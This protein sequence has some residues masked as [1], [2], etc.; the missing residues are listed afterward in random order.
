MELDKDVVNL[1]KAIR[2]VESGGK[3]DARS[4][5]GS[6][7]AY[8]FIKPT[9]DATAKK[10]GVNA[11][12][13][14][15]TP[16]QQNEVAYKQIKEW[17]DKGYNVGQISSM[18]NAGAGRPNAYKEGLSGVNK[19]GV[20]YNVAKYAEKV[21]TNYQKIKGAGMEVPPA[22]EVKTGAEKVGGV[23]DTILGGA[24]IGEAI[25]AS[26]VRNDIRDGGAI[27]GNEVIEA[28][29]SK[30]S[31]E[32]IERLRQKGVPIS[33]QAQIEE[34]AQTV[35]GPSKTQLFG[36]VAR[37]GLNFLP[38]G[39]IIKGG[40]KAVPLLNKL[41]ATAGNLIEGAGIAGLAN[42]AS[43]VAN[44]KPL[45]ENLGTSLALGGA[46]GAGL[47]V[48]IKGGS[49]VIKYATQGA[50]KKAENAVLSQFKKGVKPLINTKMTAGGAEKYD[51]N[52]IAG[53][54]TIQNNKA[55]LSFTDEAGEVFTGET[56]RT[57]QQF[58]D[59]IEQTKKVIFNSYDELAKTA[60][61][62]GVQVDMKPI[63][64]ELDTIINNKALN[65]TN[66]QAIKYAKNLKT[67][68]A[69]TGKLDATT[70]QEV[71][72]NYNKSLEAFYRNPSYETATQASID[73]MIANNMRKA[74]DEGITGL[75]GT[76]YGALKKQYGALKAIEKDVIKASLRDA[77]KNTKGLIDFT[78]VFSGGQ[79]VNGI[80]S[81]NPAQIGSGLAQ[82][83]IASFYKYL[84]NPNRAI[85]KLFTSA[86]KL[87]QLNL[88]KN[89]QT[90]KAINPNTNPSKNVI[91]KPISQPK[92]KVKPSLSLG[93]VEK[94]LEPLAQEARK[95]KSA[96]AFYKAQPKLFR[97]GS[98]LDLSRGSNR[99]I[100]FTKTAQEAIDYGQGVGGAIRPG[101]KLS[102][103]YIDPKAN[104]LKT[105]DIPKGLL[106]SKEQDYNSL[107]KYARE[108]G[109]DAVEIGNI[110]G[111]NEIRVLN[112]KVLK[113]QS[114]II[115]LWKKA[116]K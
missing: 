42:T 100:S 17:K 84:N 108:K 111:E 96:E 86:E 73:A 10:Y 58:S 38:A 30:L 22:T 99:G 80:L 49:N 3:F 23:L 79:V 88:S 70:A 107:I 24:K 32:A 57:L 101:G 87:P 14:K 93:K 7:G 15:A 104:I 83:G 78:D 26:N 102:S 4:K 72:Q 8:Q 16:Q 75:T 31:P 53:V 113:T 103:A 25:G 81:L 65:I 98:E 69:S 35:E 6:Y 85:E 64:S 47:P 2:Q 52:I 60:G 116:N 43:N 94:D 89:F 66:P 62:A 19:D 50:E 21:A 56:P 46:I 36:D 74:L 82:K 71:V 55:N 63:A 39:A 33:A 9:W 92:P 105:K 40:A 28:D 59:S 48:L 20:A 110:A 1:T 76:Q 77:R 41:P 91:P 95:Y 90:T 34:T 13:E 115:D 45:T 67:R 97:Y 106:N 12:W 114:Q 18:W 5:D 11:E 29:Y 44:E 112:S 51:D 68:L 37:V 54:K 109:Y 27:G 61:K